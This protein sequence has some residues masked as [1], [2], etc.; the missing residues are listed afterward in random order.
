MIMRNRNILVS[1]I[2][3]AA[4]AFCLGGCAGPFEEN[5]VVVS[6]TESSEDSIATDA[7]VRKDEISDSGEGSVPSGRLVSVEDVSPYVTIGA[8][9]GLRLMAPGVSE[10]SVEE[11][12][13]SRLEA[14][15]DT[16]KKQDTVQE[17]DT[18][19]INF[20]GTLGFE[21][22]PACRAMN[23]YLTIGS[24][25]M[26]PGFEQALIGMKRGDSRQFRITYPD[27]AIWDSL[28]GQAVDF[29]VTLQSFTRPAALTEEWAISQ[30]YESVQAFR[31]AVRAELEEKQA[32]DNTQMQELA[33]QMILDRSVVTEYP[34]ADMAEARILFDSLM[35]RYADQ[36]QMTLQEFVAS[37][38]MSEEDY[39]LMAEKYAR[40]R[41]MQNLILQGIMDAEGIA[42]DDARSGEI[43]SSLTSRFQM[44]SV[45]ALEEAFGRDE[46]DASVARERVMEVVLASAEGSEG[47]LQEETVQTAE[48]EEPEQ[49]AAAE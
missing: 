23:Y 40:G 44:E 37:Q 5:G 8:Y 18:V 21:I 4:V 14:D 42:L 28:R 34:E 30:G 36:G 24:G 27:E 11:E 6:V 13:R 16:M 2:V 46:V 29:S 31:D 48:T 33:W 12:I 20:D 41:V 45:E 10:E 1:G 49:E 9:S 15:A 47:A 7:P 25:E 17:G 43:R 22:L 35:Q 32:L 19:L 3:F 38:R 26:V 39:T